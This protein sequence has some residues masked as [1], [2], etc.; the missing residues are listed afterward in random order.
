MTQV[1]FY[2]LNATGHDRSIVFA[3]RLIEKL[4]REGHRVHIH[5]DDESKLKRLDETLWTARDVSFI[6]HQIAA[7]SLED[8]PVTLG[9]KDFEGTD[10]ILLNFATEIPEFFSHFKRVVEVIN[11][12]DMDIH[13]GRKRYR[14][15]RDRGYPLNN[16]PIQ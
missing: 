12:Q 13:H 16:H 7:G 2:I 14:F 10:E 1:D 4:Y 9:M 5:F 11:T 3:A 15:Y 6:P 8:C